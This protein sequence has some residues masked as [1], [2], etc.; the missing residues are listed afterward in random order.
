[1]CTRTPII[2]FYFNLYSQECRNPV[3]YETSS[4]RMVK[5]EKGEDCGFSSYEVLFN[6]EYAHG[7]YRKR[8]TLWEVFWEMKPYGNSLTM[9]TG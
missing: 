3:P 8:K 7:I 9:L 1:M 2:Y 4:R 6:G 5:I